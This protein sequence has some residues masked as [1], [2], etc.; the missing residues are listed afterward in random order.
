MQQKKIQ[1]LT[2]ADEASRAD[3]SPAGDPAAH[4]P[5]KRARVRVRFKLPIAVKFTATIALLVIAFMM[6]QTYVAIGAAT[7]SLEREINHSGILLTSA[8]ASTL[9]PGLVR[10]AG[11]RGELLQRLSDFSK[12]R[13]AAQ[14]L[15][16]VVFDLTGAI[17]T[18][19]GE[20]Q[21]SVS[22]GKTVED[23]DAA[24][25]QVEVREFSY[26]GIPV[27]SFTR[28]L[29]ARSA[30]DAAAPETAPDRAAPVVEPQL[31]G[32]IEVF[33]SA[34]AIQDSRRQLSNAMIGVSATACLVAAIGAFLLARFLTIPIRALVKDM[35]QVSLGNLEHQ[36]KVD[37]ADEMGDLA[38]AFNSMTAGLKTAQEVK[39]SQRALE[40]ELSLASKIQGRLLPAAVPQIAGLDVALY[41]VSAKE[42]SGD[43]YDFLQID[44]DHLG[45][46]VADVSGKGI[47]A[48]LIMTTT[49]SLLRAAAREETSPSRTVELVNRLLTPDMNPGMFV[50]LVYFMLNLKTHEVELVR[51]G[52]N[53][54]FLFSARQGKLQRIQ[55]RG[56]ALGLARQGT[57]FESELKS[58]RFVLETGDVL[59]TYS[60]GVVEAKNA[61]GEDYTE[62]RFCRLLSENARL[63]ANGLVEAVVKDV[64]RHR[65][66][67]EQSD[68]IT[69]L[70]FKSTPR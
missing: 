65:Q 49:R 63:P 10:D 4:K 64:T 35:K 48:S 7:R 31:V 41:F 60:D 56:I 11:R 43:Y 70:V 51:A 6:W 58:Q 16:V 28:Q 20:S 26:E 24:I 17:G 15:N 59:V 14:V 57:L 12:S 29:F 53:T 39:L 23:P 62:T 66:G 42:V 13:G 36:S 21:F 37:T 33:I 38:R 47:P 44:S 50:T 1:K 9:D 68:D 40:H 19:R 22:E 54:P 46:V 34:A 25:A 61:A 55:P 18:A 3:G 2:S 27:R 69:L 5:P 45:V 30:E 32:R 67:L 52:H 8:M